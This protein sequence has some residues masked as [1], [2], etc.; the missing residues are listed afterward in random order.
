MKDR[1]DVLKL[2]EAG[3]FPER[4]HGGRGTAAHPGCLL[5][6]EA[7][8]AVPHGMEMGAVLL[9]SDFTDAQAAAA[10]GVLNREAFMQILNTSGAGLAAFSGYGLSIRSPE[11]TE[12]SAAERKPLLDAL[13]KNYEPIR[14]VESFG[15]GHTTLVVYSRKNSAPPAGAGE[16]P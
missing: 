13:D 16:H 2:R 1:P 5:A 14:T 15:Q 9:L 10:G 7:N 4:T 8:A 11:V 12:L 6:V 3:H